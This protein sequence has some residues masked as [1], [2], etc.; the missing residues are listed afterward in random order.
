MRRRSKQGA[1]A[2]WGMR[3]ASVARS[4]AA[5]TRVRRTGYHGKSAPLLQ[6]W[7]PVR[8]V[9]DSAGPQQSRIPCVRDLQ[10]PVVFVSRFPFEFMRC[11]D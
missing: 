6:A 4:P 3:L 7:V 11:C 8:F 1:R 9:V 2:A 5:K 10:M